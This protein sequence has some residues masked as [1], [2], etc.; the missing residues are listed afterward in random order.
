M[1]RYKRALH[2]FRRDLRIHDNSALNAALSQS[3]EV[4]TCFIFNNQQIA[5]HPYR[6]VNGLAFMLESLGELA[7]EIR[8]HGGELLLLKGEPKDLIKHL[9]SELKIDA[10]FFNKDYTPFSRARDIE[11]FNLCKELNIDCNHYS[12]ALLVEP[13][14]FGKDDGKPYTVYTPF[15]KRASK[16]SVEAPQDLAKG[17]FLSPMTSLAMADSTAK[18]RHSDLKNDRSL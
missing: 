15:F 14:Q 7:K 17:S 3:H 13:E 16:L 18:W 10:V 6:S 1:P 12:D 4:V 11:I 5:P 8:T 2:I 9:A